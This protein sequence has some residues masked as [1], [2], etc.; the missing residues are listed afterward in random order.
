MGCKG[1]MSAQQRVDDAVAMILGSMG[2]KPWAY[3]G[4]ADLSVFSFRTLR[5]AIQVGLKG[6]VS[7]CAPALYY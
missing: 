3:K 5:I 6:V 7:T 1:G 4:R 2:P